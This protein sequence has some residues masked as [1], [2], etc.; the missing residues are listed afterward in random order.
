MPNDALAPTPEAPTSAPAPSDP[1]TA[2]PA[3]YHP[4]QDDAAGLVAFRA[5]KAANADPAPEGTGPETPPTAPAVAAPPGSP[6]PD[7]GLAPEDAKLARILNRISR[8]EDERNTAHK[9]LAERDA[10]LARLRERAAV[11]DQYDQ[12]FNRFREDPEALFRKVKWDRKT[13][14]DYIANG[15]SKVDA[16]TAAVARETEELK[17]RLAKFEQADAQRQQ[18]E[19][20]QQFKAS[21]PAALAG[22]E[23]QFPLTHTFYDRPADLADALFSVMAEAY[24]SQNGREMPVE[25]A[26]GLLEKTLGTHLERLSR[27]RSK[28]AP[29]GAPGGS[30][31]SAPKPYTPTLTN[32]PPAAATSPRSDAESDDDLL[33][34]AAASLKAKRRAA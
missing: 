22:K 16:A 2:A 32:T 18:I 5:A 8:L 17:A 27:P 21:L 30:P 7:D 10:E 1:S 12:D 11:A 31:S 15:P 28:P 4:S 34:L 14:E 3:D 33:A 20:T 24:R 25:E 13:I 6:T 26:A 29:Q 23:E 19:R 9:T